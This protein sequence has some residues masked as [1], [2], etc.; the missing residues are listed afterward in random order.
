MFRII[1]EL[2]LTGVNPK[3]AASL[4]IGCF[5]ATLVFVIFV[6]PFHNFVQA[7]F[8]KLSGDD[9]VENAGYLTFNPKNSFHWIG[10]LS[11]FVVF[12]GFTRRV[13]YRRRFFHRPVLATIGVSM[14]GVLVYFFCSVFFTFI[15]T[16]IGNFGFY[17]IVNPFSAIPEGLPYEGYIFHIFFS[18][19]MFL[20]GICMYSAFFNLI[21]LP[22]LDMGE[23]L[24]LLFNSHWSSALKKNDLIV[25]V[26]IFILA[27][28]V[29]GTSDS[30]LTE[31]CN[32]ILMAMQ[33]A[34]RFLFQIFT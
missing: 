32:T 5:L 23:V 19:I 25:S 14:S 21:P 29:F 18:M 15:C 13:R 9:W 16:L 17:G 6:G 7:K 34:F 8:I 31:T 12:L 24:F 11:S 33:D 1:T 2:E 30:F 22:P 26:V 27:F 20:S 28:F 10:A 4:F 3:A